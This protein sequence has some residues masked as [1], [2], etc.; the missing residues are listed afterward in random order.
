MDTEETELAERI[1]QQ[2]DFYAAIHSTDENPKIINQI[3]GFKRNLCTG[4]ITIQLNN[5]EDADI[6]LL[7]HTAWVPAVN[8]SLRIKLPSYPVIVHGIPTSFDLDNPENTEKLM[9]INEGILDSLD[10]IKWAN[11]HSI[12]SGKPF[13]SL[14][15][16]LRD[17]EEANKAIK[18]RL[19][20]FSLLKVVE[21]SSRRLGQCFNCLA[22]GHSTS[23]CTT[24]ARCPSCGTN[25]ESDSPCPSSQSP[26]CVN[27]IEEVI[28]NSKRTNP[29]FSSQDLSPA[30]VKA[31]AHAA[32][33]SACP[34]RRKLAA[35]TNPSEFFTV[36]KKNRTTHAVR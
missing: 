9:S 36:T 16:H 27:C 35:K 26:S 6:A 33:A 23:R 30:Q 22:Y 20:F 28:K 14:I 7:L 18:N 21:K 12:E 32:T 8:P 24:E 4:E 19:N 10:S 3:R 11:R 25:H 34:I 13:S 1:N 2:L 29:M 17:P 15:I 5:Q 31:A